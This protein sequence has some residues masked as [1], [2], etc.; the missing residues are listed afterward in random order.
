ML[1]R[2]IRE[3]INRAE[4]LLVEA[5]STLSTVNAVYVRHVAARGT[6][7][8]HLWCFC[9]HTLLIPHV[10]GDAER[11]ASTIKKRFRL[12]VDHLLVGEIPNH[13]VRIW[14]RHASD[15]IRMDGQ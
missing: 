8:A 15:I 10:L 14:H 3:P 5:F 9:E 11:Y 13:A 2:L 6:A 1:E 4:R 12:K 7:P